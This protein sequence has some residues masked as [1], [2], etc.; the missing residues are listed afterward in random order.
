MTMLAFFQKK[1]RILQNADITSF[2]SESILEES[3][4]SFPMVVVI[5][6]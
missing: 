4:A 6:K 3:H 1:E 2:F 5:M